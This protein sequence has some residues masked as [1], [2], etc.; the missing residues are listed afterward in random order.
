MPAAGGGSADPDAIGPTT[1]GA[2]VADMRQRRQETSQVGGKGN[3]T[4][5]PRTNALAKQA[6]AWYLLLW[7]ERRTAAILVVGRGSVAESVAG[8]GSLAGS[9]AGSG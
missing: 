9:V 6:F 1:K 7:R 5:C 3:I 8:R 4:A 2:Y